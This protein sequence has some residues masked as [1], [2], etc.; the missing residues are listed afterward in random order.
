MIFSNNMMAS[1]VI[2][3]WDFASEDFKTVCKGRLKLVY[4]YL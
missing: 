2:S 1:V 3:V 4:L